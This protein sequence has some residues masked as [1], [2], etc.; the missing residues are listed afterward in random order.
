MKKY[1]PRILNGLGW[2]LICV[3]V[4]IFI[5]S[6]LF[7][8]H[9][10]SFEPLKN[11]LSSGILIT[12]VLFALAGHLFTQARCMAESEEKLS[13]FYLE[14]CV[15]AYEEARNLL[16]DG[17]NERVIWIAAGRALMHAKELSER[18]TI[19]GHLRVLELHKLKYRN[20]FYE[21]LDKPAIFFYGVNDLSVC[22][23][24][25]AELSTVPGG[26][27]SQL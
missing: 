1:M 23:N 25:A 26:L 12:G 3:A 24:T 27:P 5:S 9:L 4:V 2:L 10:F 20:F 16:I 15:K 13:Q 8:I 21:T 6:F 18:V 14:S 7:L 19:D 11:T 22:L 17:N